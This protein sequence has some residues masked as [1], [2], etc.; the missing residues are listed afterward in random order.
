M[1][2][3]SRALTPKW[4]KLLAKTS[5]VGRGDYLTSTATGTQ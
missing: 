4:N 2:G 5:R 3:F 1:A